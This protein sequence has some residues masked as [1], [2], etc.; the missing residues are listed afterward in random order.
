MLCG[1]F[2][3][4]YSL[5]KTNSRVPNVVT[6]LLTLKLVPVPWF[7]IWLGSKNFLFLAELLGIHKMKLD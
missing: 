7:C 2:C 1:G 3:S 4:R 5:M 6:A